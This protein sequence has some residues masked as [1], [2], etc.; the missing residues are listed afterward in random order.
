MPP[1]TPSGVPVMSDA[2]YATASGICRP[3]GTTFEKLLDK[4]GSILTDGNG[5]PIWVRSYGT[6]N[7]PHWNETITVYNKRIDR[8]EGVTKWYT[9]A[10]DGCF[11]GV[12]QDS[13]QDGLDGTHHVRVIVRIP[14]DK[15]YRT[16]AQWN[17]LPDGFTLRPGDLIF[18]GNVFVRIDDLPGHRVHDRLHAYCPDC[19]TVQTVSDN[20]QK[21]D[22]LKHIRIEGF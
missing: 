6:G 7:V 22:Y 17:S 2:L 15:R 14:Y 11:W 8:K 16:P 13:A 5:K 10:V 4:N 1:H 19:F 3:S 12:V 18:R 20:T 21:S 9:H